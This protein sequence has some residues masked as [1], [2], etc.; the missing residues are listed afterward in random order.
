MLNQSQLVKTDKTE[1]KSQ[2]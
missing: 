1:L 2:C